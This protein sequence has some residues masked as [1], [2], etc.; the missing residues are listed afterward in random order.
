MAYQKP[1]KGAVDKAI[2]DE[3]RKVD[4][5]TNT[6]KVEK[7]KNTGIRAEI[8][9]ITPGYFSPHASASIFPVLSPRSTMFEWHKE[10]RRV[11]TAVDKVLIEEYQKMHI[12]KILKAPP[13]EICVYSSII[14]FKWAIT[15]KVSSTET[16]H[17][18]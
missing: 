1:F 6:V 11:P 2:P 15:T 14:N 8:Y 7:A 13:K 9:T 10:C 4:E 3:Q 12:A 5:P 16:R 18:I 17:D